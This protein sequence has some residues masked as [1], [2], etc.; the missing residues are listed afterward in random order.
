MLH[1]F[2][3]S[4]HDIELYFDEKITF[5]DKFIEKLNEIIFN[6]SIYIDVHMKNKHLRGMTDEDMYILKREYVIC[7]VAHEASK[8]IYVNLLKSSNIKKQLGDFSVERSS[9]FDTDSY[10]KIGSDAEKCAKLLLEEIDNLSMFFA[11]SFIKGA[12]IPSNGYSY[13]IWHNPLYQSRVPIA[14]DKARESDGRYYKTGAEHV[15]QYRPIY[16]RNRY[17]PGT[18]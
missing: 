10:K 1:P 16:Y 11:E 8:H 7:A 9:S 14:A 13:R 5:S 17:T 12:N 2:Y 3:A 15:H 4:V 6:K 18:Y